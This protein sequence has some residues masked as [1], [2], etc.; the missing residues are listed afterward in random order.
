[1]VS[2]LVG[3]VDAK[4]RLAAALSTGI[5]L[6]TAVDHGPTAA[7][8]GFDEVEM[9]VITIVHVKAFDT[10][11]AVFLESSK[12]VAL[13]RDT[14]LLVAAGAAA[15]TGCNEATDKRTIHSQE[16]FLRIFLLGNRRT[17][18]FFGSLKMK[19][20]VMREY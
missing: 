8:G 12:F 11:P 17:K 3:S 5:A 1:M 20:K 18:A 16:L 14:G 7:G 10:N 4:G 9:F 19:Q 2:S 6:G 13:A 15:L